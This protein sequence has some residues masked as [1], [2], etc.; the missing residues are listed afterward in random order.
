MIP[1][2]ASLFARHLAPSNP[3]LRVD[4]YAFLFLLPI[5]S[6]TLGKFLVFL[7]DGSIGDSYPAFPLK[8]SSSRFPPA[9]R[10]LRNLVFSAP[11]STTL[12]SLY[13]VSDSSVFPSLLFS[14]SNSSSAWASSDYTSLGLPIPIHCASSLWSRL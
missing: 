8:C 1:T 3:A 13:L 9:L 7:S 6:I 2:L 5:S 10:I 12:T 4:P 14:I 11:L